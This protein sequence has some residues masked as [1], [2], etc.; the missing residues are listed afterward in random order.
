MSYQSEAVDQYLN[1]LKQGKKYFSACMARGVSPYPAVLKNILRSSAA[2]AT[3]E[4]GV[5]DIPIS[6]ITGTWAEGRKAAF[7]GNSCPL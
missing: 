5:I 6:R 1:A 4:L 7:A 3:Q 2:T